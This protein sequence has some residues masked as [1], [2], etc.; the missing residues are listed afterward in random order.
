MKKISA[1]IVLCATLAVM[2]LGFT[3]CKRVDAILEQAVTFKPEGEVHSLNIEVNAADFR[4]EAGDELKVESNLKFLSVSDR[5]GVWSIIDETKNAKSYLG[6]MLTIYVPEGT[7]FNEVEIKTGAA[8]IN[9]GTLSADSVELELGAGDARFEK[10]NVTSDIEIEGGAGQITIVNGSLNNLTLEM[11]VGELNL[12]ATLLGKSDL[13][14]GVGESNI[15]LIG[16][17]D[18]YRI[19]VEK[20]VGTVTIDGKEVTD[21]G[22]SG[23]GEAIVDI[24]GGIGRINVSFLEK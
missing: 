18:D 15:T 19:D 21:F 6:A 4:I 20:G 23:N 7:V 11:G 9:I 12:T 14:L 22:S 5:N 1:I 2:L 3:G 13:N 10:L 24:D 8:K 17:K 16:S